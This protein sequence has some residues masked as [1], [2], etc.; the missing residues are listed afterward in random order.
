[1]EY[2]FVKKKFFFSFPFKFVHGTNS[3]KVYGTEPKCIRAREIHKLLYYLVYGYDGELIS[4]QAQAREMLRTQNPVL[5]G[6]DDEMF[7]DLPD[8]YKAISIKQLFVD[9]YFLTD[10]PTFVS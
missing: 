10:Y 5:D 6:L 3:G 8:I 1:M 7:D 9:E 4:D 2:F